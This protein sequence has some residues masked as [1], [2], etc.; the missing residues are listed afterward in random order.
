MQLIK[1]SKSV[2]FISLL[3]IIALNGCTFNKTYINRKKDE[4]DAEKVTN[5]FFKLLKAK[6]YTDTFKL[7]SDQFWRVTS[8]DKLM[9]IYTFTDTK[10]GDLDST[11]VSRWET[12]SVEGTNPSA[13]YAFAYKTKHSKYNA[14]ESIKL[15]R[16][17]DG[18]I[19]ILAYS[20]NSPGFFK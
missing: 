3:G 6:K 7:Y 16:E 4:Q 1:S 17:K 18:S 10:L 19:K 15:D 13:L 9:E 2:Y 5:Q 14:M 12:R 20:V 11:K 8:K